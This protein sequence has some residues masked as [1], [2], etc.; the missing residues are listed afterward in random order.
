MPA[1]FIIRSLLG[2][3]NDSDP[4][5]SLPEDQCTVATNIEFFL[6]M[7]G[8]RRRG[9]SA[10][11]L[12]ASLSGKDRI[13]F[14]HR[15]VP[16]TDPTAAELWALGVTGTASMQLA[17]KTT[18][19]SDVTMSDTATLTG[20]S[21]YQWAAASLHGKLFICFDSNVDR[22]H[23]VDS[24]STTM[25]RVGLATPA[26]PT[27]AN[28]GGA[29]TFAG[30]RYYRVR[31]TFQDTGVT[32]RRSEPSAVLTFAPNGNDTGI[33][34]TKPASINDGRKVSSYTINARVKP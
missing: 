8:E 9:T 3:V 7:L 10:I 13:T 25:R 4:S 32:L 2:G 6:S 33:T 19:W 34:V 28:D 23:V 1:D 20:F 29:G 27:G 22:L 21:Q 18:S 30:T 15:H 14:L 24:G 17:R 12:P 5:I 16:G 11:T 31:Y 26:A